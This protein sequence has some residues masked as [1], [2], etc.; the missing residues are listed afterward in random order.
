MSRRRNA[1]TIAILAALFVV[2]LLLLTSG[3]LRGVT[4]VLTTA[5]R[6]IA[7]PLYAG[8]AIFTK[9]SEG[10]ITTIDTEI[11]SLRIE[12][13]KLKTLIAENDAL[14]ASLAFKERTNDNAVLVRVISRTNED[15]FHGLLIDRGTED[16]IAIGQ[17]V[18][19]ENGVIIGKIFEVQ[20]RVASVLLLTDT[21]SKL[22]ISV[23]NDTETTGVLEGDRGLSMMLSL[24]PQTETLKP[25]DNI[26]TSGIEPG[27]RRG[28]VVGTIE[29]VNSDSKNPFESAI[30]APLRTV[31]VPTFLQVLR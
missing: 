3:T 5:T 12:N 4:S 13:A 16:G 22:A 21:R 25:G 11:E 19:S 15:I 17:P 10:K 9:I 18:V 8:G 6:K 23:E 20:P 29:K 7:A 14:K 24:V 28:L 2:V 26:I 1:R 30:V 27:I 31:S